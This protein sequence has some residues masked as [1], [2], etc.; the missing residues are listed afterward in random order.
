MISVFFRDTRG[1]KNRTFFLAFF[2]RISLSAPE[3]SCLLVFEIFALVDCFRACSSNVSSSAVH[4]GLNQIEMITPKIVGH[5][6][7]RFVDPV[8]RSA[9]MMNVAINQWQ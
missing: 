7:S 9:Q 8:K 4:V 1:E 3:G 6:F 5:R 2:S